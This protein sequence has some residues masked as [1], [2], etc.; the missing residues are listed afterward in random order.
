MSGGEA[1][2][3][4]PFMERID[5]IR[6]SS[7]AIDSI[8]ADDTAGIIDTIGT[9]TIGINTIGTMKKT[10]ACRGFSLRLDQLAITAAGSRKPACPSGQS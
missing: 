3:K 4:M 10:P 8:S 9:N 5:A 2:W 6:G 7:V 1:E